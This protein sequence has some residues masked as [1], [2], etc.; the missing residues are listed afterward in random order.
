MNLELFVD[1]KKNDFM[2]TLFVFYI[3][4]KLTIKNVYGVIKHGKFLEELMKY[5]HPLGELDNE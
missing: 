2:D 5:I 1:H 3:L 4:V